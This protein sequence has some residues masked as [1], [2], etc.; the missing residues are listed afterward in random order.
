MNFPVFLYHSELGVI[1]LNL[2]DP[3]SSQIIFPSKYIET[4][5]GET[6]NKLTMKSHFK[7]FI[8]TVKIDIT[9]KKITKKNIIKFLILKL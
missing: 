7:E 5:D 4:F 2:E 1:K 9:S 8:L 6:I 3:H